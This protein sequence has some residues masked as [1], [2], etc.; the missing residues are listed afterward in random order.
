[1][2]SNQSGPLQT[3][4]KFGKVEVRNSSRSIESATGGKV[5]NTVAV[6][7]KVT[8]KDVATIQPSIDIGHSCRVGTGN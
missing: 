2:G 3:V 4:S 6:M 5:K 8:H 1:M 7:M